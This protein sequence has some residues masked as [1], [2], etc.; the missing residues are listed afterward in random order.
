MRGCWAEGEEEG[1]SV[2]GR[3]GDMTMLAKPSRERPAKNGLFIS[4]GKEGDEDCDSFK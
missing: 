3:A 2:D 4:L 1:A